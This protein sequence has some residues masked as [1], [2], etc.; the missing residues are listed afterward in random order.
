MPF[1]AAPVAELTETLG[2]PGSKRVFS[3][4]PIP[5][6]M[7]PV[8]RHADFL[9]LRGASR[10]GRSQI[11]ALSWGVMDPQGTAQKPPI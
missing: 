11:R 1:A 8:E 4:N 10:M 2:L 3:P 6:I 7:N 5:R 9:Q